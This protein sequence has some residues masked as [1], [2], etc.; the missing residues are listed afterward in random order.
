MVFICNPIVNLPNTLEYLEL[1]N[2]DFEAPNFFFN[3]SLLKSLSLA[4]VPLSDVHLHC[5]A[6]NCSALQILRIW[7]E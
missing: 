2:I 1:E 6:D 5:I 3:L 7:G 4:L